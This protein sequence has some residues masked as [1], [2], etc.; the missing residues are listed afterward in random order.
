L[1]GEKEMIQGLVADT[2]R[3]INEGITPDPIQERRKQAAT[4]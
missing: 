1:E 3:K 2:M 4:A